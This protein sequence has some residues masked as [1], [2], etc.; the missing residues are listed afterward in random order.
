MEE[1]IRQE[2]LAVREEPEGRE[3]MAEQGTAEEK[4]DMVS[5]QDGAAEKPDM[6]E[7][8]S[9]SRPLSWRERWEAW[10]GLGAG[11]I[12]LIAVVS[13][14]IDHT[15]AGILG[16]YLNQ[17]GIRAYLF[18]QDPN[19]TAA[20]M[21]QYGWLYGL[22]R[23][24]RNV[25]RLA[26]PIYCYFLVEGL[27]YTRNRWKYLARLSVFA[28]ISEIPFDLL[29]NNAVLEFHSQNVY[30]TLAISLAVLIGMREVEQKSRQRGNSPVN[31]LLASGF[32]LGIF[33]AGC[34][35]AAFLQTDYSYRGVVCTVIIYLF[36]KNRVQQLLAGAVAFCW[37]LPA[38]PLAFLPLA[39]YKK[40]RGLNLKY[41]FYAFYPV[42]LLALY[43]IARWLG[44]WR[45]PAL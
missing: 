30:F 31:F 27:K 38:A 32:Q 41:F 15:A 10:E 2:E 14:L 24:M 29:F 16:R 21:A 18:A 7:R 34:V 37:E 1:L 26:F 39:L 19:I 44:I 4:T 43:L 8:M 9:D 22:Y 40:K 17:L 3:N 5:E 28:L 45:L 11:T 42:H 33:A 35:L 23:F 20:W 13:M 6:P 36:S 25:G 12:K